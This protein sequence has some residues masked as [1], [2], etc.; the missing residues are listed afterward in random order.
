[1]K[2]LRFPFNSGRMPFFEESGWYSVR[3]QHSKKKIARAFLALLLGL[4]EAFITSLKIM[5][6]TEVAQIL[7][8]SVDFSWMGYNTKKH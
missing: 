2:L 5:M 3:K 7:N 6:A 4:R 8:K 1:M